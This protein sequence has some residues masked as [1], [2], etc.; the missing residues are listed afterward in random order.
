NPREDKAQAVLSGE[1][2]AAV[3]EFL[4]NGTGVRYSREARRAH[5]DVLR[6]EAGKHALGIGKAIGIP[7]E[8][9]ATPDVPG[10]RAVKCHGVQAKLLLAKADDKCSQLF[11]RGAGR[12]T[13]PHAQAPERRLA[14][15]TGD[16]AVLV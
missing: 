1:Q 10:C 7:L 8:G 5:A 4:E 9:L 12:L 6:L 13:Q 3:L 14:G 11:C 16:L 2:P 15:P